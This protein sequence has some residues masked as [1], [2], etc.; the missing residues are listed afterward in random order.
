VASTEV[1][2]GKRA[3]PVTRFRPDGGAV[4]LLDDGRVLQ[5]SPGGFVRY[6]GEC[7][8][9]TELLSRQRAST[10][11]VDLSTP[12]ALVSTISG[13]ERRRERQREWARRRRAEL[14]GKD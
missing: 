7:L 14:K 4:H 2:A 3:K 13:E 8:T 5:A 11:G 10:G 9:S 6:E 1:R 12:E